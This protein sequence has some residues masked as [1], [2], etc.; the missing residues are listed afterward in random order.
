MSGTSGD[1][2]TQLCFDAKALPNKE[3]LLYLQTPVFCKS[4]FNISMASEREPQRVQHGGKWCRSPSQHHVS[5]SR[6]GYIHIGV[7]QQ[8]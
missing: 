1:A 2:Y 6:K 8:V 7:Q 3:K 4:W 5:G